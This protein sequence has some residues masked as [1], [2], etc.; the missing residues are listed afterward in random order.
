LEVCDE[1]IESDMGEDSD[2]EDVD[3]DVQ[4]VQDDV[5]RQYWDT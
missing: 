4:D 5:Y 3:N 1:D 2:P